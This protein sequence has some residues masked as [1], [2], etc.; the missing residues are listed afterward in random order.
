MDSYLKNTKLSTPN[1]GVGAECRKSNDEF[2][3]QSTPKKVLIVTYYWPPAGGPGVQR[4][5]KFVKYLR[6]FGIDPVVYIPENPSYPIEDQSLLSEV[7]QDITILRKPIFEPYKIA[8]LLSKKDTKTISAGLIAEEGKQSFLQKS[9]LYIR[10]NFFVPDARKF[11][12]KPSVRFLTNYLSEKKIDTI[13][14]TGPPHSLHL[15]GLGLKQKMNIN[16]IADFRDPWTN[17]GYQEK[18]KLSKAAERKHKEM[19]A[20]VLQTA[21]QILTTSFATQKEFQ[22]ITKKPIEVI[23]NGYDNELVEKLILDE[24]FTVSHIGSLLAGRNPENLW[25]VFSELVE[26]NESFKKQF[27]LQ[28][29]G[30]IGQEVL[31]TIMGFGLKDFVEVVGYVS[32]KEALQFQQKS[33]VLLLLEIDSV[34]T[35]GIIPGKLFEYMRSQRP[36]FAVG[37]ENWDV[38]KIISETETG[39]CFKYG[40]KEKMKSQLLDYFLKFQQNKLRSNPK[41][42]E[43]Y[44]RRELTRKLAELIGRRK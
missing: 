5:L 4:W 10:G 29:V 37:P 30:K 8:G 39:N 9:L 41:K 44:S 13:I 3:T 31:D 7:P 32:H 36:I 19:E 18:L 38:E 34:Q 28:L 20:Q 1:N 24:H 42:I 26:E 33:Q 2:P 23:T 21:D 12:V 22:E 27:R 35:R 15:I 11:W 25:Q 43:K 40:E 17:I 14:T 6:D 16:W